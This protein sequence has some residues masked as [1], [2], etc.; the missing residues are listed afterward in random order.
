MTTL[1]APPSWTA[2]SAGWRRSPTWQKVA[3]ILVL[4]SQVSAVAWSV[5][6]A[7]P[8]ETAIRLGSALVLVGAGLYLCWR[9]GATAA[10]VR[11]SETERRGPFEAVVA[12]W[13]ASPL[14]RHAITVVVEA[15]ALL[16][17]GLAIAGG[18]SRSVALT[19]VWAFV[20]F[21]AL[22][23]GALWYRGRAAPVARRAPEALS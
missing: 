10:P 22:T 7:D 17:L 14:W 8:R 1:P 15:L 4:A 16:Q 5:S 20:I 19:A 13:H 18:D 21:P 3:A 12:G 23:L 11:P 6:N 2:I 9:R